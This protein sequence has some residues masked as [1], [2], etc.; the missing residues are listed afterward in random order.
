MDWSKQIPAEWGAWAFTVL[1]LLVEIVSQRRANR[2]L[3]HELKEERRERDA[4]ESSHSKALLASATKTVQ[5]LTMLA[6][7]LGDGSRR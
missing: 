6:K 1:L 5:A 7:A 3:R 4:L 2:W